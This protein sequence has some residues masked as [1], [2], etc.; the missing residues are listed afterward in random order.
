MR[1]VSLVLAFLLAGT[2]GAATQFRYVI[3]STGDALKPKRSGIVRVEG[4]C[5]RIDRDTDLMA[6]AS[7][8]TDG[9]KTVIALNDSLSTYYRSNVDPSKAMSS[10]HYAVPFHDKNSKPKI[11]VKNVSLEEE[12]SEQ[13]IAGFPTRKYVLKFAHDVKMRTGGHPVRVM[14]HSTVLLWTTDEIDLAVVPM[15]LRDVRTALAAV[16]QEIAAALSGVK[17]F[18]LKRSLSVSRQYEGGAVMT[19]L[20]TTT[21]DDFKTVALPADALAVPPGYRYQEPMIGVPGR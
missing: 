8:S 11:S 16:D 12:P 6:N 1:G 7:F 19:D 21:F 17:G 15:D 4:V 14:F 2:A 20:V 10:G 9:G 3:E 18:P 13:Q 5:Y